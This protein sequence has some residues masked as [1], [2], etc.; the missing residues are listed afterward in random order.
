MPNCIL[1]L[2]T[3]TDYVTLLKRTIFHKIYS[4]AESIPGFNESTWELTVEQTTSSRIRFNTECKEILD[5]CKFYNH[6][7]SFN[8]DTSKDLFFTKAMLYA[9]T[10]ESIL[11]KKYILR[12]LNRIIASE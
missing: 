5:L 6:I 7:A 4:E 1:E 10:M 12:S 11:S 3:N 8:Y 2:N 9:L